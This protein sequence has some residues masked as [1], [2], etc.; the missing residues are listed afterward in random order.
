MEQT[1]TKRKIRRIGRMLILFSVVTVLF[2]LSGCTHAMR[3]TNSDKFTLSPT[4]PLAKPVKLGVTS[5]SDT[6]TRRTNG[7]SQLL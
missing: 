3:I 7:M 2:L 5:A 1:N 4:A 6:P